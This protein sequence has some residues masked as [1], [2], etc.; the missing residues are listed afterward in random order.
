MSLLSLSSG[1]LRRRGIKHISLL[2][3]SNNYCVASYKHSAP[4][5]WEKFACKS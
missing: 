4:P 3:S 1:E 2:R 5:G